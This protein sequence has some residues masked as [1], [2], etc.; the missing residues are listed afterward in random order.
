M[1]QH[2]VRQSRGVVMGETLP[3]ADRCGYRCIAVEGAALIGRAGG[4]ALR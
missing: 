1:G 3:T 4:A 2:A